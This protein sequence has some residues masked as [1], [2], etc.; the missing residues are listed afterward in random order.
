MNFVQGSK[1]FHFGLLLR[2]VVTSN[3]LKRDWFNSGRLA[4]E[5]LR[6]RCHSKMRLKGRLIQ[7]GEGYNQP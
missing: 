5:V 3:P 6:R 7:K 1:I 4:R 2:R